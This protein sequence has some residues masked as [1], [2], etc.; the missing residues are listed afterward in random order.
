MGLLDGATGAR[1]VL[2]HNW[3]AIGANNVGVVSRKPAIFLIRNLPNPLA[4][5]LQLTTSYKS[6]D[7]RHSPGT[8]PQTAASPA[9]MPGFC[10]CARPL[11]H[12]TLQQL[13]RWLC[14]RKSDVAFGCSYDMEHKAMLRLVAN[15]SKTARCVAHEH[16]AADGRSNV[17]AKSE[18]VQ[19]TL[20]VV[21]TGQTR[22]WPIAYIS[23]HAQVLRMNGPSDKF[24]V[25][26]YDADFRDSALA[27]A[28]LPRLRRFVLYDPETSL[29]ISNESSSDSG[30][31][32]TVRVVERSSAPPRI[33]FVAPPSIGT[34]LFDHELL[35]AFQSAVGWLM[36][37]DEEASSVDRAHT[38][39][40]CGCCLVAAV[41]AVLLR[42]PRVRSRHGRCGAA[43]A[44]A[45][46]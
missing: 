28:H 40:R 44:T 7:P 22:L 4:G 5:L 23:Q 15:A 10:A 45:P 42:R 26:A 43:R 6:W 36:L 35:Q 46:W 18:P 38:A 25:T 12:S 17:T 16:A 24:F 14:K 2:G 32:V 30:G 19:S 1:D 11:P 13:T 31:S 8:P 33:V 3:A 21:Y 34:S 27:I 37:A 41:A 20:A 9:A 39:S 29:T